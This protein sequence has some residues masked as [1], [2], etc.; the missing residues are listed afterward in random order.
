[1]FDYIKL[2]AATLGLL[3]LFDSFWIRIVAKDFYAKYLGYLMTTQVNI[4]PAV[5]FYFAYAAGLIYF[6][7]QPAL[8]SKSLNQ[9]IFSGAFLG[10]ISYAAYDLTNH[11]TIKGWYWQMTV[12]DLMWG[13]FLSAIVS[14]IVFKIFYH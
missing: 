13:T 1:M 10:F 9:A 3:L 14:A 12:V 7:I 6:V 5:I 4:W 8:E 2:F 11:A